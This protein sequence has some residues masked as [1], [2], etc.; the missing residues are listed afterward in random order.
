[1]EVTKLNGPL[2]GPRD[3]QA[4]MT[5]HPRSSA[6]RAAL[7]EAK[8]PEGAAAPASR[9]LDGA[10]LEKAV[11]R[12]NK[13]V[14]SHAASNHRQRIHLD[15]GSGLVVARL[16]EGGSEQ[17]VRQIPSQEFLDVAARL[18]ELGSL[19]VEKTG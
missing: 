3:A 1:M 8:P 19:L 5:P 7:E 16:V 4:A 2:A 15:Q 13:A 12:A 14:E 9:P 17:V 18:S 6:S 10:E 11:E